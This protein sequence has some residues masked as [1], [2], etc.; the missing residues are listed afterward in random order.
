MGATVGRVLRGFDAFQ[1]HLENIYEKVLRFS[2]RAPI[3]IIVG[4]LIIFFAS[5]VALKYVPKTF[6][7]PQDIGEF[8]VTLELPAGV[9]LEKMNGVATEVDKIIRGNKEVLNSLLSV[10]TREGASNQATFYL[11]L[12]PRKQ[13]NYNT[14][15]FKNLIR[16][17]LKPYAYAS[18]TV[19]DFDALGGGQR[20]FAVYIIGPDLNRLDEISRKVYEA[21]KVHPALTDPTY[22]NKP[23]KPEVQIQMDKLK[24]EKYG[25]STS[26]AGAELRTQVDGATPVVFRENGREYDVR[27]RM[28]S[29]QRDLKKSFDEIL[30]PNING[31]LVQLSDVAAAKEDT[32]PLSI[33]RSDRAR[34]ISITSDIAAN[35]PGM[36]AAV[37]DVKRM[38]E[39]G[40]TKL[41]PGYRYQFVGQAESFQ[42][43]IVNMVTALILSVIFI[44]LVLASLYES[45]VVPLTIMVVLPL[46]VCGAFYSL[47]ITG[48][49]LDINSMIGC[50]LLIGIA[51]KNSI[52]LVDYANQKVRE[53]GLSLSE[54]M[55]QAG[56]TRLR[57]ILMTT[58]ALIAGMLPIA[59]GLNEVSKQRTPMGVAIIGGLITSTLLSLLV[60]PA[61]YSYL[62]RFRMWSS[63]V[64]GRMFLAD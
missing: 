34:Y 63:K 38:L 23:G 45:F 48:K 49:S 42:E 41:P 61:V 21:L 12:V 60:V 46:A 19:G 58:V 40:D 10:G 27:V 52:L 2:M 43:L 44:Y 56:R 37:T 55:I 64:L 31:R 18:P 16:E 3:V 39:E 59:I 7:P 32:A 4:A 50:I 57:P 1:T 53:D 8:Q 54:A 5:F 13:R 6:L 22:G 33:N 26:V 9:S 20:P 35:G 30:V 25:V 11:N 15:E 62:E 51:T 47:A 24:A 14:T 17:Q 36:G 29:D 28:Q